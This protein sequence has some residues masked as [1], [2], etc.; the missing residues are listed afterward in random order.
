MEKTYKV[1][2]C[3]QVLVKDSGIRGTYE[4]CLEFCEDMGWIACPDGG[5]EW[6]LEIEEE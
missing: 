5:F 3:A 1:V 6:D 2:M 4:R